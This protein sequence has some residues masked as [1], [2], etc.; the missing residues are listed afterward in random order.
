MAKKFLP[1]P[2]Q[3][4]ALEDIPEWLRRRYEKGNVPCD[5][6]PGLEELYYMR[7]V[8]LGGVITLKKP[9]TMDDL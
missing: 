9:I 6:P 8:E 2:K 4:K 7:W 5:A 3:C 1:P